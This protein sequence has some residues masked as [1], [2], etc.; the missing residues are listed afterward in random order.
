MLSFNNA[1]LDAWQARLGCLSHCCRERRTS[2]LSVYTGTSPTRVCAYASMKFLCEN[3]RVV[4]GVYA[5]M[6][7]MRPKIGPWIWLL[8]AHSDPPEKNLGTYILQHRYHL[9]LY[10]SP[11]ATLIFFFF[12]LH[13]FI[14]LI[15]KCTCICNL[16]LFSYNPCTSSFWSKHI[17][18][19]LCY[20]LD[21]YLSLTLSLSYSM[22]FSF[23]F[24]FSPCTIHLYL[25]FHILLAAGGQIWLSTWPRTIWS[26]KYLCCMFPN[27]YAI[28]TRWKYGAYLLVAIYIYLFIHLK[29]FF[30]C[31]FS[32]IISTLFFLSALSHWK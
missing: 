9:P 20:L 29:F 17:H 2:T 21:L 3:L 11:R 8:C 4:Y 19:S 7:R 18:C 23:S 30:S 26:I 12:L 6:L 15:L 14:S 28:S 31:W 24:S 22:V 25:L 1:G 13:S 16:N 10:G 32:L 5:Q 27:C